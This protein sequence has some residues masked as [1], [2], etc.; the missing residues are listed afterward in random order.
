[1]FVRSCWI[2]VGFVPNRNQT[3]LFKFEKDVPL[4]FCKGRYSLSCIYFSASAC[5]TLSGRP[6]DFVLNL[7]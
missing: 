4:T 2:H 5:L 3:K 7:H 1:M 6:F